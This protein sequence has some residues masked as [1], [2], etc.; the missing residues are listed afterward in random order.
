MLTLRATA[1]ATATPR[2]AAAATRRRTRERAAREDSETD[3]E[4]RVACSNAVRWRVSVCACGRVHCLRGVRAALSFAERYLQCTAPVALPFSC[5]L[6]RM[7]M[8][9]A[10]LRLRVRVRLRAHG[11][12]SYTPSS[13]RAPRLCATLC[14]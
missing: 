4:W 2:A 10:A 3:T 14:Q 7:R 8:R 12:A 9:C 5:P 13:R 1:M 11:S 6:P